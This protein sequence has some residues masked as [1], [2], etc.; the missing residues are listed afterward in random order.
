MYENHLWKS[1]I[2]KKDAVPRPASLF[3]MSLIHS[4]CFT[5]FASKNQLPGFSIMRTLAGNDLTK[6]K[7]SGCLPLG[8]KYSDAT[9]WPI[10]RRRSP[11]CHFEK[12]I[13]FLLQLMD[14]TVLQVYLYN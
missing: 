9:H 3:K 6:W 12:S 10:F 1:D 8:N 5:H 2:L 7:H 13:K 14:N 4:F 11:L